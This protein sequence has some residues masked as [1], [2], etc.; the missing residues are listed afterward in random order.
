VVSSDSQRREGTLRVSADQDVTLNLSTDG[1]FAWASRAINS[2][3]QHRFSTG[4]ESYNVEFAD[5]VLEHPLGRLIRFKEDRLHSLYRISGDYISEVHRTMGDTRFT[6]SVLQVAR[7]AEGKYLPHTYSV[8]YWN[9]KTGELTSNRVVQDTWR[10]VGK[11][12]LPERTV[13]VL[14]AADG[15]RQVQAVEFKNLRLLGTEAEK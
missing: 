15:Q 10:R 9:A 11:W 12:D 6:I 3:V 7:N 5:E 13:A 2:L 14:T 8:S 4:E 1:E